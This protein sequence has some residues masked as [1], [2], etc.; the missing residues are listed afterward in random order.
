MT[1]SPSKR[2]TEFK[3]E[4]KKDQDEEEEKKEET[5]DKKVSAE[6]EK[7]S[8]NEE[9]EMEISGLGEEQLKI[10]GV[11]K[12][13]LASKLKKWTLKNGYSSATGAVFQDMMW[14][15]FSEKKYSI[16]CKLIFEN[17]GN[18]LQPENANVMISVNYY[19]DKKAFYFHK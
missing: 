2:E 18:G 15:R 16:D 19:K 17:K 4:S 11:T 5:E 8:D 10:L 1:E 14:I 7:E 6:S 12:K 13:E 3:E 9:L